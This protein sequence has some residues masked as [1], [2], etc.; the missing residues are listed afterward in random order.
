MGVYSEIDGQEFVRLNVYLQIG[1]RSLSGFSKVSWL[2]RL[3]C[4]ANN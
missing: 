4:G 3:A 1:Q 2:S